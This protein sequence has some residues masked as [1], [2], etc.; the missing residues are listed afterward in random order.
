MFN[1]YFKR[2]L[3]ATPEKMATK[4]DKKSIVD[5]AKSCMSDKECMS[6]NYDLVQGTAHA[7]FSMFKED[8]KSQLLVNK[9]ITYVEMKV[10]KEGKP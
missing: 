1:L 5:A 10:V 7:I 3:E 9:N 2:Q 4:V 6:F 8:P